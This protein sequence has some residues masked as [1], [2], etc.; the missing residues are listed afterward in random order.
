[1]LFNVMK[2]ILQVQV[3]DIGFLNALVCTVLGY[4]CD[5][6]EAYEIMHTA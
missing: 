6:C 5:F 1:M 2:E 4:G 3:L